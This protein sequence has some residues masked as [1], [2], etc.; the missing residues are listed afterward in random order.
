MESISD[1]GDLHAFKGPRRLVTSSGIPRETVEKRVFGPT[2][3]QW[4][5]REPENQRLRL[6]GLKK[7]LLEKVLETQMA[8]PEMSARPFVS[9]AKL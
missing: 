6:T 1:E 4:Y 7:R 5:E 8:S 3:G 9:M 2:F